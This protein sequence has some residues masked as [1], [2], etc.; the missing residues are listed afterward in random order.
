MQRQHAT[1][2]ATR[3][4][5]GQALRLYAKAGTRIVVTSGRIR[6]VERSAWSGERVLEQACI[7][8]D[9][10]QHLVRQRGWITL[11]ANGKAALICIAPAEEEGAVA[12]LS[13][14]A[15]AMALWLR[16]LS[17]RRSA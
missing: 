14:V 12:R 3:L 6:V 11:Q 10:E 17:L 13:R 2:T 9:G 7:A 16:R 8:C 4:A 1:P 5:T 15:V